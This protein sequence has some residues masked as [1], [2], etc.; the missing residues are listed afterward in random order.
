MKRNLFYVFIGLFIILSGCHSKDKQTGNT[1]ANSDNVNKTGMPIVEEQI[2]LD[3]FANESDSRSI[4]LNKVRSLESYA[5]MTNIDITW[6][7]EKSQNATEKRN[8]VLSSDDIPDAFLSN[9]ATNDIFKYGEQGTFIK[10]NDLIE[11]YAP[12][13]QA[14]FDDYPEIEQAITFP[15]GNIYSLPYL[16][17]PDFLSMRINPIL[18]Y[19]QEWLAT[20]GM[21][22]PETTDDFYNYLKAVKEEY[23][24]K[25]P[26]GG[27]DIELL[28]KWLSGAFGVQNRN[29]N[30]IDIDPES[31]DMRFF[32]ISDNYKDLLEYIHKLYSEE[33]I[34]SNIYSLE[35]NEFRT[36][37]ADD[38][39]GSFIFYDPD[40]TIDK[41]IAPKIVAGLPLEGPEGEREITVSHPVSDIGHFTI[42]SENEN[43]EA[44]LRWADHFYSEEGLKLLYLGIEG[45]SYEEISEGEYRLLD[46]ITDPPNGDSMENVL[47]QYAWYLVSTARPTMVSEAFFDGAESTEWSL[48]AVEKIEPFISQDTWPTFTYTKEEQKIVNSNMTDIE[49]YV[50]EM[51]DNFITGNASFEEWD[52]YINTIEQMG[53]DEY[54]EIKEA[55]YQRFKGE[56]EE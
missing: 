6:Q 51:R 38:M 30:Y 35:W 42:T 47:A 41:S 1:N 9:F 31:E 36:F 53:L 21:D 50:D 2:S 18:Q 17:S 45:E 52:E 46:D 3:I 25:V 5:E 22:I 56:Y 23:P 15:D 14:I 11:D 8:I 32:P 13:L 16:I 7:Q 29:Q 10:L 28:V 19:N 43:P 26:F 40:V 12:N 27:P 48:E 49:K 24:D 55:A 44:T 20:V 34:A 33:L 39:Y 54:M 37:A 4:D